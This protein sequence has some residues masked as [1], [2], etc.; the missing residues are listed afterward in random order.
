MR[1][2]DWLTVLLVA[3]IVGCL[4]ISCKDPKPRAAYKPKNRTLQ[5]EH[6]PLTVGEIFKTVADFEDMI[7]HNPPTMVDFE[8]LYGATSAAL[9]QESAEKNYCKSALKVDPGS[10]ECSKAMKSLGW[11][12]GVSLYLLI[13]KNILTDGKSSGIDIYI[14]PATKSCAS[15]DGRNSVNIAA[16]ANSKLHELI[17][18]IPCDFAV[19]QNSTKIMEFIMDGKPLSFV[20]TKPLPPIK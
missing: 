9:R 1:K 15:T 6:R 16:L 3:L 20:I 10:R 13:I 7:N 8:S 5:T 11:E 17:L 4:V 14:D 19:A 12:S 18:V 2:L